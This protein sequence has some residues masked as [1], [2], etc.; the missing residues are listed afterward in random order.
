MTS[1]MIENKSWTVCELLEK[2]KNHE[3]TK[4]KY[5]RK[6]KWRLLPDKKRDNVP[7]SRDY[8]DFLFK[9][10]NSVHAISI[11]DD[12]EGKFS[13][14]DGNNRLYTLASF[15]KRPFDI[16]PDYLEEINVVIN[17]LFENNKDAQEKV[18]HFF[19]T[20][21]YFD[22]IHFKYHSKF[23]NKKG[24]TDLYND[25]L[26]NFSDDFEEP[27][28]RLQEKLRVKGKFEFDNYVRI[29]INLFTGYS[30]DELSEVFGDINKY[31]QTLSEIDL[32][33]SRLYNIDS[34]SI[35][36]AVLV[37]SIKEELRTYYDEKSKDEVL[38]CFQFETDYAINAYDFMVGYQNLKHR[39]CNLIEKVN[40]DGSSLFFKIYKTIY[41]GEFETTFTTENVNNFIEKIERATEILKSICDDLGVKTL[42]EGIFD[43]SYKNIH[44]RKNNLYIIF[45]AIIGYI[46]NNEDTLTITKS[47]QRCIFFHLFAQDICDKDVRKQQNMDNEIHYEAGGA[48]IDNQAQKCLKFPHTISEKITPVAMSR[49]LNILITD[50]T[51]PIERYLPNGN[52]QKNKRRGRKFFEKLLMLF[53]FK[54]KVPT[55]LLKSKFWVDHI[56]VFSSTWKNVLDIDRLGNIVPI[57]AEIN[58]KRSNKHIKEYGR[59]DTM[60]F[61][62]YIKDMI[63][64][65]E[66]YDQMVKHEKN[67]SEI[68][69][70]ELYEHMC[71]NNETNYVNNFIKALF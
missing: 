32:L 27:V 25:Y 40:D 14:I 54:S 61:M 13:N 19:S 2:I 47:I 4:P 63:P 29:N 42:D 50:N 28:E 30:T 56:T 1:K 10:H 58:Q 68:V 69:N 59:L 23:F 66:M 55:D 26:K 46:M 15:D 67:K 3:I 57:V 7:N 35:N 34:F 21:S 16:Y 18:R 64:S 71:T 22:I 65:V 5:Q 52:Q 36:D 37:A 53:Y 60:G 31:N 39:Y 33:A 38:D 12:N 24:E 48:F 9:N 20:M 8:I 49:I 17:K 11:A 62:Q 6:K 70:N 45:I 43:I 51:K 41:K 44:L